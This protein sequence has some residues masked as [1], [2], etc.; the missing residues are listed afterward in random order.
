[1]NALTRTETPRARRSKRRARRSA[2]RITTCTCPLSPSVMSCSLSI[3]SSSRHSA[4]CSAWACD[5]NGGSGS[6]GP[7]GP[8]EPEEVA[9]RL[10][11]VGVQ[12]RVRARGRERPRPV[13]RAATARRGRPAG[14]TDTGT[15]AGISTTGEHEDVFAIEFNRGIDLLFVIDNSAAMAE[16][17]ARLAAGIGALV[18]ELDRYDLRVGVTTTASTPASSWATTATRRLLDRRRVRALAGQAQ[19][20]PEPVTA[21]RTRSRVPVLR[22]SSCTRSTFMTDT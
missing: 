5:R 22:D 13:P 17:Q 1:M 8:F 10:V 18:D 14:N 9:Q 2:S 3:C 16:A 11:L 20:L 21:V 15:A 4:A 12:V 6:P 7:A 19:G